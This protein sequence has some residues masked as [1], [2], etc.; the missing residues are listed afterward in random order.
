MAVHPER[1]ASCLLV[2]THDL[3]VQTADL[4]YCVVSPRRRHLALPVLFCQIV[5]VRLVVS[6]DSMELHHEV[7]TEEPIVE[8]HRADR[9]AEPVVQDHVQGFE[10]LSAV[11]ALLWARSG[12]QTVRP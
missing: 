4:P 6:T 9:S 2:Q 7:L 8:E 10:V 12:W 5:Q 3:E 11:L 1:A